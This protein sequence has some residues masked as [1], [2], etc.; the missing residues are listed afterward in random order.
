MCLPR[1]MDVITLAPRF[2][3]KYQDLPLS[4]RG[5]RVESRWYASWLQPM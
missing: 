2:S 4:T 1:I 5:A 3:L